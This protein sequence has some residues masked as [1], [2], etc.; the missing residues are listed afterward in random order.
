MKSDFTSLGDLFEQRA[1]AWPFTFAVVDARNSVIYRH[2]DNWTKVLAD[3]IDERLGATPGRCMMVSR[4]DC[5]GVAGMLGCAR[6]RHA[7]LTIDADTP[8]PVVR[9]IVA[10][11]APDLLLYT[12]ETQ[13]AA[14]ALGSDTN[15]SLLRIDDAQPLVANVQRPSVAQ[16]DDICSLR[17]TSGTTGAAKL[18]QITHR[19]ESS[20]AQRGM[21]T[22]RIGPGAV[23]AAATSIDSG[24]GRGAIQRA[25]VGGATLMPL[26]LLRESPSDAAVRLIQAGTTHLHTTPTA[27]RILV[28]GLGQSGTFPNLR[29]VHFGGERTNWPDLVRARK[30]VPPDC[31]LSLAY[32]S[33]ETG[34]VASASIRAGDVGAKA[35]LPMNIGRGVTVAI[36]ADDGEPLEPRQAGRIRVSGP[37][38]ATGNQGSGSGNLGGDGLL[39][40]DV[41]YLTEDGRLVV[42]HRIGAEVKIRGQRV[43]LS[44]LEEWL[45]GEPDVR[46]AAVVATEPDENGQREIIAF[47]AGDGD[48]DALHRHLGKR[49]RENLPRAMWPSRLDIRRELPRTSSL[50]TDRRS[51]FANP[52]DTADAATKDDPKTVAVRAA[53]AYSLG[54]QVTDP[55][56]SF[57]D[58]G[59]DSVAATAL[60]LDLESRL[61]RSLDAE[62]V[63]RH[64]TQAEQLAIFNDWPAGLGTATDPLLVEMLDINETPDD[65]SRPTLFIVPGGDGYTFQFKPFADRLAPNWSVKAF[66]HPRLR[67]EEPQIAT[68]EEIASRFLSAMD[69]AN[70]TGRRVLLGYSIGGL[71]AHEMAR[72]LRAAGEDVCVVIVDTRAHALLPMRRKLHDIYWRARYTVGKAVR[73]KLKRADAP[74][75]DL[76][77]LDLLMRPVSKHGRRFRPAKS[78]LPLV[79]I[80]ANGNQQPYDPP[81]FGWSRV[82]RLID[83]IWVPG[84]H[85]DLFKPDYLDDTFRAAE[86][87]LTTL[88]NGV[89]QPE[90]A[91]LSRS[92]TDAAIPAQIS[93]DQDWR[94]E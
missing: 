83:V 62:F 18:I 39:T 33:T 76:N 50:K 53:W 79:L 49:I 60:A 34:P 80:R 56:K 45:L 72:R 12:R 41:G 57:F 47:V 63:F 77:R 5:A 1:K 22:N 91:E 35:D 69:S 46:H 73:G 14:L 29:F 87:G 37:S 19:T 6:T 7:L 43:R 70:T 16:A 31:L 55:T 89:A 88:M 78:D 11:F 40:D 8:L 13:A 25:L 90:S 2:L 86:A 58:E 74:A 71:I 68:I 32:S 85:L 51:I 36:V 42:D 15:L 61:G 27:F 10:Q 48:L 93:T 54:R 30:A 4:F 38:V 44:E 24:M 94:P 28:G 3:Q 21:E 59:G 20:R 9:N 84:G 92:P 75:N 17:R 23:Y 66:R 65:K 82:G 26:D 64:Q 52:D 67:R 81:D